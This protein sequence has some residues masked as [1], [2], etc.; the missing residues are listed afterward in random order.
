MYSSSNSSSSISSASFGGLEVEDLLGRTREAKLL[1]EAAGGFG[2]SLSCWRMLSGKEG[3]EEE[4]GLGELEKG[5][6]ENRS[7]VVTGGAS[8]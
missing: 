2:G 7:L 1:R 3:A 8:C 6:E 4:G 5:E